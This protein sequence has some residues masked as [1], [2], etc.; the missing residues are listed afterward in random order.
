MAEGLAARTAT[1]PRDACNFVI[2]AGFTF[3]VLLR[4]FVLTE[5]VHNRQSVSAALLPQSLALLAIDPH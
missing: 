4:I 3:I 1:V 2:V 5:A